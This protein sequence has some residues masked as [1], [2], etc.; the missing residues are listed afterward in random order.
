MALLV[1]AIVAPLVQFRAQKLHSGNFVIINAAGMYIQSYLLDI[2]LGFVA[3]NNF[4]L[5]VD[6][7]ARLP[8]FFCFSATTT[9]LFVG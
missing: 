3:S 5:I 8:W 1:I 9:L 4:M 7:A 6:L 2:F